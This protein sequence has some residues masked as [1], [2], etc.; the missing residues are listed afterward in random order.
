MAF[1]R[2]FRLLQIWTFFQ[3]LIDHFSRSASRTCGQELF[4]LN[5]PLGWFALSGKSQ[6]RLQPWQPLWEGSPIGDSATYWA[7]HGCSC[8]DKILLGKVFPILKSLPKKKKNRPPKKEK[9]HRRSYFLNFKF[10]LPS[11][12]R[13]GNH[14]VGM[15]SWGCTQ[16]R[17]GVVLCTTTH[18]DDSFHWIGSM[19]FFTSI[20]ARFLKSMAVGLNGAFSKRHYWE[21]HWKA[22]GLPNATLQLLLQIFLKW[23]LTWSLVLTRVYRMP[24]TWL[25]SFEKMMRK[26][27]FFIQDR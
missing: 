11:I 6:A 5:L 22:T 8:S 2:L 1:S 4:A 27:W 12:G 24:M 21:F 10:S 20:L 16:T 23:A 15:S 26:P 25:I 13:A 19:L 3:I 7:G 14:Q 18:Q 9:K 17:E